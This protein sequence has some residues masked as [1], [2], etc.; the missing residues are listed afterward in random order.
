MIYFG[1]GQT[2]IPCMKLIK[3]KGGF[4]VCVYNPDSQR[5]FE[6]AKK[7]FNDGRVNFIAPAD[8]KKSSPLDVMVKKVLDNIANKEFIKEKM[9]DI[10]N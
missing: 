4:S 5:A 9:A 8:Y 3:S 2:D 6:T 1:D 10:K 7:I